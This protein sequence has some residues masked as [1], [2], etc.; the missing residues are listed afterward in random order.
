MDRLKTMRPSIL[1]F[2]LVLVGFSLADFYTLKM[3]AI[4]SSET[5]VH[6][7]STR[8]HI[9]EDG[10]LHNHPYEYLRSYTIITEVYNAK[11]FGSHLEHAFMAWL[12]STEDMLK[13]C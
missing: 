9:P 4:C 11:I 13:T 10:I 3:E 8:R 7:R 2:V 6:T 1:I 5:S 12:F